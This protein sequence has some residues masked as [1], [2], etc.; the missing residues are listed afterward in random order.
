MINSAVSNA[1]MPRPVTATATT[2]LAIG[3]AFAVHQLVL[4]KL[5]INHFLGTIIDKDTGTVLEYRHL[6]K[7]PATKSAWETSFANKKGHLFK[8]IRDLKGVA[9][10]FFIQK[11]LVPTNKRPTNG[12]IVCNFC[13]QKKEQNCTRLTVGGNQIDYPGNKSTPI[14]DLTTVKLLI[15]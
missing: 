3:Y 15:S 6:A 4:C 7:N 14:A 12:R 1:L 9:M 11:S 10:C 5:A 8:G 13:T 2:P